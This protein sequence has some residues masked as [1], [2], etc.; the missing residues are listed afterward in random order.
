MKLNKWT[1]WWIL[2]VYCIVSFLL[3]IFTSGGV[4]SLFQFIIFTF[5]YSIVLI[6]A[7][8]INII[9]STKKKILQLKVSWLFLLSLLILQT[10]GLLTNIGYC[11][12]PTEGSYRFYE[13]LAGTNGYEYCGTG[14]EAYFLPFHFEGYIALYVL[15]FILFVI[16]V[17]YKSFKKTS[18]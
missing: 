7:L 5:I 3:F 1:F 16:Q 9:T 10:V 12:F 6:F 2:L 17:Y 18:K 15:V 14:K 4:N 8:V 13:R 11:G